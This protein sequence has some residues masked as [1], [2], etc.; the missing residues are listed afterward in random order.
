M[1][2]CCGARLRVLFED[3]GVSLQA[4]QHPQPWEPCLGA[5]WP[6]VV[7]RALQQQQQVLG[8]YF[9]GRA[10]VCGFSHAL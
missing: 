8:P 9:L 6:E 10:R 5:P 1:L 2:S 7:V 3:P 4:L